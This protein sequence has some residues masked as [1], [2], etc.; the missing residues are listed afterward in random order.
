VFVKTCLILW[1]IM[2][3]FATVEVVLV[4]EFLLALDLLLLH[5]FEQLHAQFDIC[6]EAL[7]TTPSKVFT[8]YYS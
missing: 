2:C 4:D 6:D 7:A 3:G 5:L 8:N 1:V